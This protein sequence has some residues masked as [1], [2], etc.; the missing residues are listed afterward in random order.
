[1]STPL[2]G[3]PPDGLGTGSIGDS[4]ENAIELKEVEGLSQSQ[5]VRRRFFRHRGAMVG[6]ASISFVIVLAF[7]SVGFSFLGLFDVPGWWKHD[8]TTLYDIENSAR[9]TLGLPGWLGG[10]GLAWGDFPFGQDSV[11]HDIFART[12]VGAQTSIVVMFVLSFVSAAIGIVVGA[13]A[14]FFRGWLDGVL[15]RFTDLFITFPVLVTGAVLGKMVSG[16]QLTLWLAFALGCIFWTTLARLVRA[17]F[18]TLR[19]REFVDA[20]RVAGASNFRIIRKHML[21]NAMGVIIVNTTLLLSAAVLLE[22]ALSYLG[23]G[24]KEPGVSLGTLVSAA[25]SAFSTRPWLFWWPGVFIIVLALAVN[26]IG[27][28]LRDAFDPRQKK[29]PSARALAKAE[30]RLADRQRNS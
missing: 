25:Q 26:F 11:G 29:I 20:A 1:M 15:M 28:G 27:D 30:K 14:G 16:D 2:G 5:I 24:I 17:E 21:P 6:L 22:T 23:F 3:T 13:V 18:L 4:I 7:S 12:M 8:H 9:P 19:E 10:E